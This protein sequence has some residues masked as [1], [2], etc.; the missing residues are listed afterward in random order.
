MSAS[1]PALRYV[2]NVGGNNRRIPLPPHFAG[3]VQHLLD[4]DPT[5]EP[6]VLADAREL[7]RLPAAT[8]DAI[9]CSHNLEHYHDHDVPKVLAGFIHVLKPGAFAHIRVP[10][11]IAVF[12]AMRTRGIDVDQPL[13][14]SPAGPM[15]PLDVVYGWRKKIAA[16]GVDFYAHKTGFSQASLIRTLQLAGFRHVFSGCGF[17]EVSAYAFV[18]E[19]NAEQRRILQ[20]D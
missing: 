8:Y 16:S 2:L 4:I 12:E 19:P 17:F 3:W 18:D 6:D 15:T 20:I 5:G 10:D 13:Y 11:L 7:T 14:D 9:Y 1:R